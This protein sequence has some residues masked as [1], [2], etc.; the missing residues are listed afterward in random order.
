L[1]CKNI[2]DKT[3]KE[4]LLHNTALPVVSRSFPHLKNAK[5]K[6][7]K[8]GVLLRNATLDSLVSR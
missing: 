4:V 2:Y 7:K 1:D 8:K 6:K 3:R 5:I